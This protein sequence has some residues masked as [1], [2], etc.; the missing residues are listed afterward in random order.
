MQYSNLVP[1]DI[2]ANEAHFRKNRMCFSS[3]AFGYEND[4][5]MLVFDAESVYI[6]HF[7]NNRIETHRFN[8]E[9]AKRSTAHQFGDSVTL[10]FNVSAKRYKVGRLRFQ[11]ENPASDIDQVEQ[12]L[13]RIIEVLE[14][15]EKQEM[16]S[17]STSMIGCGLI[18]GVYF[19][20]LTIASKTFP[21]I[22]NYHFWQTAPIMITL[23]ST[24][25]L[26]KS[27]IEKVLS[28]HA[29]FFYS[30]Y[31]FLISLGQVVHFHVLSSQN[32]NIPNIWS[33][34]ALFLIVLLT[35]IA[36]LLVIILKSKTILQYRTKVPSRLFETS[37]LLT[38]VVAVSALC[39]VV[40]PST[41]FN[42]P[43]EDYHHFSS[44]V[45]VFGLV[46]SVLL[47][48]LL[49]KETKYGRMLLPVLLTM[50][51]FSLAFASSL[52]SANA[53][54][55]V[56]KGENESIWRIENKN[57]V[58]IVYDA[59][60]VTVDGYQFKQFPMSHEIQMLDI[61]RVDDRR[62]EVTV[63]YH[64]VV[65]D[66]FWEKDD[67]DK[68]LHYVSPVAKEVPEGMFHN[69][70][71]RKIKKAGT[72]E[73]V[74][75]RH[76]S[77]KLGENT[78]TIET[79]FFGDSWDEKGVPYIT[80]RDKDNHI[81]IGGLYYAS[82]RSQKEN[83]IIGVTKEDADS[84]KYF[85]Y[86]FN[87]DGTYSKK[88]A[89]LNKIE[90]DLPELEKRSGVLSDSQ[91]NQYKTHATYEKQGRFHQLKVYT[92]DEN[93]N[94]KESK[95]YFNDHNQYVIHSDAS[96]ATDQHLYVYTQ[97]R[98][99][100]RYIQQD[101]SFNETD[102]KLNTHNLDQEVYWEGKWYFTTY[103]PTKDGFQLYDEN[104]EVVS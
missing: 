17:L 94:K 35:P 26:I 37:L 4:D 65:T 13:E 74:F 29:V 31:A 78:L 104:G 97:D 56:Y 15:R 45:F 59:Y 67:Q 77:K 18:V 88:I 99:Q 70:E 8:S 32:R 98:K 84:K 68:K 38:L 34:Y 75:S 22:E 10:Y 30:I 1:C 46:V 52:N 25:F 76:F 64:G 81:I 90:T 53:Y 58:L 82:Y 72:F 63:S 85:E 33:Y 92:Y 40:I 27:Y 48:V 9:L 80:L 96:F 71:R 6:M 19:I 51:A 83:K 42:V 50:L 47:H 93:K 87:A 91:V 61:K 62:Y 23:V 41:A 21:Q 102:S 44:E 49:K 24:F 86:T 20:Y 100:G 57:D 39:I 28:F 95:L 54:R 5:V 60:T 55:T 36:V 3:D 2:E 73:D 101:I 66:E 79:S 69:H 7:E 12:F 16:T 89:T 43:I 11:A 14:T 103:N